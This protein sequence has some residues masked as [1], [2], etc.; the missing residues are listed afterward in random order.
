MGCSSSIAYSS[1]QRDGDVPY[2]Y[3]VDASTNAVEIE[4]EFNS[5]IKILAWD[6]EGCCIAASCKDLS[7]R[8]VNGLSGVTEHVIQFSGDF[9][10]AWSPVGGSVA[11]V[12]VG[13]GRGQHLRIWKTASGEEISAMTCPNEPGWSREFIS[14]SPSGQY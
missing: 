9:R 5:P 1:P 13:T 12:N 7:L 11:T 4:I 2:L 14:W 6:P 10:W 3:V 8:I